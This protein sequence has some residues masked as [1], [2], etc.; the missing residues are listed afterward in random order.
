MRFRVVGRNDDMVVVRGLN[1]FPTMVAAVVL[2]FP[3]LTG[4]YRITLEH[5]PPYDF[6]P[7]QVE[8]RAG[9]SDEG[10]ANRVAEALKSSLGATARVTVLDE[11]SLP[12]TEG[13]TRRVVR[14]YQ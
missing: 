4:D 10:L 5:P 3:E 11:G 8:R 14:A 1:L 2:G 9:R 7:V 6:L 13:K 12:V